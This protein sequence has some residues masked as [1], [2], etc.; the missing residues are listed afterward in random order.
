MSAFLPLRANVEWL[1]KAAKDR[2]AALR[3]DQPTA[4]LNQ[5]QLLIAQE[6][7]FSSWKSLIAHV[8]EV[9]ETL[10]SLIP[11]DRDDAADST[12]I[13]PDDADLAAMFAAIDAGDLA[14]VTHWLGRRPGLA[15]AHGPDGQTPLHAAARCNDPRLAVYLLAYGADPYAKFGESA[16]TALSWG[17]T[18]NSHEFVSTLVRLGARLDLFTAA[19]LGSVADLAVFFDET[20]ALRP[21]A[22]RSG[23][24]RFGRDG[25]RL[26]CPP[27]EPVEQI[28]DAL[29]MASRNGHAD[30][31]RFLLTKQPDLTFCSYLGGTALH[32]AY[33]GGSSAVIEM[34]LSRGTDPTARDDELGCTPRAFGICA[35]ANWGFLWLVRARLDA[36]ADLANFMDGRTSALHEAARGGHVEVIQLLLERGAD[37]KLCDGDGKLPQEIAAERNYPNAALVLHGAVPRP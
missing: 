34:L 2:L 27:N 20:G 7:G 9:R 35:P 33:F 26:P 1:K 23:S 8:E 16:H 36:D 30:A 18:C 12:P 6:Y 31:V 28:S 3:A 32:W 22:V 14:T 10:R 25:A 29:C 21:G 37:P 24:S 11:P 5:A 15:K 13:S 17:V 4:E 19:G